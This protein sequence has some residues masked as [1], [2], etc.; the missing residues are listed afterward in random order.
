VN[1]LV[2]EGHLEER[3]REI[4]FDGKQVPDPHGYSF[5]IPI[6]IATKFMDNY[7]MQCND[8]GNA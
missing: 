4:L 5:P 3:S 1:D 6:D 7:M 8:D 2:Y